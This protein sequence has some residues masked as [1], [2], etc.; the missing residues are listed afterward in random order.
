MLTIALTWSMAAAFS[1]GSLSSSSSAARRTSKLKPPCFSPLPKETR[2]PY[3]QLFAD[4]SESSSSSITD[5]VQSLVYEAVERVG[6]SVPPS[7]AVEV[8]VKGDRI[9]VTVLTESFLGE[10]EESGDDEDFELNLDEDIPLEEDGSDEA[11][12]FETPTGIDV[13]QLAR[14]INQVL[15]EQALEIAEQYSIEVTTP[16]ASDELVGQVMFDAYKGFD[17]I[18]EFVDPKKK[19]SKRP[20]ISGRLVERNEDTTII[21]IKGRMKKIPNENVISVRLPKAKKEKGVK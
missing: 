12:S 5:R 14:T 13:T 1:V 9:I 21:N 16:G 20:Q 10:T 6:C 4:S 2:I 17:V 8:A 7:D 11:T 18:C 15:D 3:S 19:N